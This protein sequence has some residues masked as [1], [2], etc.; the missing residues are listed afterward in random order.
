MFSKH[1]HKTESGQLSESEKE[2]SHT[3]EEA[4]QASEPTAAGGLEETLNAEEKVSSEIEEVK[5]KLE[6]AETHNKELQD[7]LLR[8]A[9]EFDNYKKRTAREFENIIK[10]ANENL[11]LDLVNILNSFSRAVESPQNNQSLEG[12]KAGVEL[13]HG[14]LKNLL[15]KEGLEEIKAKGEKFDPALHEAVMQ[16]ESDQE[17]GTVLEEI[18][19]GYKL[20]GKVIR[21]SQVV[22]AKKKLEAEENSSNQD[23]LTQEG[24]GE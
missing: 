9:A 13:I 15:S 2:L 24:K 19:K 10:N 23:Q 7:R 3:E 1:K 16:L 12:F 22:V 17:E 5:L 21:H 14:Q 6:A 4:S 18:S 11:I 8:L 20:N